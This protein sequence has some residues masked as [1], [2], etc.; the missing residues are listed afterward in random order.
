MRDASLPTRRGFTIL[1]VVAVIVVMAILAAAAIPAVVQVQQGRLAGAREEV[2][3][4]L[5]T[6]RSSAM[7]TGQPTGVRFALAANTTQ[8]V[9]AVK[10][11]A[12]ITAASTQWGSTEPV[13][14]IASD[15]PGVMLLGAA[16]AGSPLTTYTPISV[17][18]AP[19]TILWFG[20]SGEPQNRDATTGAYASKWVSASGAYGA[21]VLGVGATHASTGADSTASIKVWPSSG[22]I[23]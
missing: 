14:S 13:R 11:P 4:R 23:E 20:P 22:M 7:A 16:A 12:A 8:L 19:T 6:A 9:V 21:V 1:E 10:T 18:S 17:A 3:R 5:A 2:L 15:F